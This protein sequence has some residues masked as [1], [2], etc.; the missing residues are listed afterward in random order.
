MFQ[1]KYYMVISHTLI[2]SLDV[3]F[4]LLAVIS[5][6]HEKSRRR[7][8]YR[9]KSTQ[10][11]LC[12]GHHFFRCTPSFSC[13]FLSLF[14]STPSLSSTAILRRKKNFAPENGGRKGGGGGGEGG[15]CPLPLVSTAMEM[16]NSVPVFDFKILKNGAFW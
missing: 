6:L 11:N 16:E 5:E 9:T 4:M 1:C 12:E 7:L 10:K 15:W 8:S 2:D 14:S 3:F 13:H